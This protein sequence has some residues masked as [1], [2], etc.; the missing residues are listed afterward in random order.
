[1][2]EPYRVDLTDR[3]RSDLLA[4]RRWLTQPGSGLRAQLRLSRI[5]RALIE[6]AFAPLRWTIGPHKGV[7]KRL[8]DGY[9]FVTA[10]TLAKG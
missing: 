5:N 9:T 4:A 7:R 1:M 3:A 2:D 6:L 10:S 8:V